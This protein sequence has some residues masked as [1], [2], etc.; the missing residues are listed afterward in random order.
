DGTAPE[1]IKDVLTTEVA[2]MED[3][4]SMGQS[5]LAAIA[6]FAPAFGMIGTLI[7]LVQML[8]TL[9]DPS[10]IGGGM[11]VALLTTLYGALIANLLALPTLGKLKVRTALEMLEK[12]IIIEGILSIQSGDNPRVVE[13]KLKAFI[14]PAQRRMLG[15]EK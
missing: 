4:H 11:A 9:D 7:G 1:L 10:K 12:E 8:A 2:F 6:S 14:S 5:I 13:Q 15:G 3:R